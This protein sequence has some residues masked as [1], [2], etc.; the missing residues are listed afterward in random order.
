MQFF[1]IK[2]KFFN[3]NKQLKIKICNYTDI[4]T[5]GPAFMISKLLKPVYCSKFLMNAIAKLFAFSS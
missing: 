4:V 2:P 5:F 3:I 1:T